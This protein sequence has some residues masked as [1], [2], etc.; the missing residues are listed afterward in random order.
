MRLM[1]DVVH[2]EDYTVWWTWQFVLNFQ[3]ILWTMALHFV[4]TS[5]LSSSDGIDF[6]TESQLESEEAK[7]SRQ[8][9]EAAKPLYE[10]LEELRNR[11]KEEYDENTKKLFGNCRL[12]KTLEFTLVWIFTNFMIFSP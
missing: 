6:N 5:V 8:A 4:K 3:L 9:A 1:V 11:K 10:Q 12:P 2:D 7:K